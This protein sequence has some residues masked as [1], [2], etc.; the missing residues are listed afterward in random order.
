M[1][2]FASNLWENYIKFRN[3]EADADK[4]RFYK[5]KV[6]ANP[7]GGMLTIQRPLDSQTYSVYCASYMANTT[8]GSTVLVIKYGEGTNL[9]NHFVIDNAERTVMETSISTAQSTADS[10][11]SVAAAAQSSA[12][13]ASRSATAAQSSAD[14][15]ARAAAS[16]QSTADDAADA[17]SD[18]QSS[19][20]AASRAATAAQSTADSAATA[21]SNAQTSANNAATAASNAQTS[22]NNAQTSAN[23]AAT[24]ASN[25]QA[26]ATTANNAANNA[27]TQLSIVED[28]AGTLAW[29]QEHGTYTATTDTTVV[30]G[31]VY[32][33]YD[34]STGDY[35]PIVAPDSEANPR[36]NGWYELDISDSQTE[37]IMAHLAVTSRGLWVL[38]SGMGT[39]TN[40]QYAPNYKVLLSADGMYLYDGSGA[41]VVKYGSSISFGSDRAFAIGDTSGTN[42][43]AF[44][45]NQGIVI[46]GGVSIGSNK[47]LA[48]IL[49]TVEIESSAGTAFKNGT[50]STTL[51]C[52]VY[53][54]GDE[55]DATGSLYSYQWYLN[56]TAISG[57]T[58]KTYSVSASTIDET[59]TYTCEVTV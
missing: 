19:A 18:A 3:K 15:A 4:V 56:G 17:A 29:I 25:A 13:S 54:Y 22:A 9:R 58:G 49:F 35:S 8:V 38:P 11:A 59:A 26:S 24:A 51:T 50:G 10:A 12:E 20:D 33:E 40:A 46:G 57:A 47:T 34:S 16:A 32:F 53:Q 48:E 39:A 43:I 1:A 28:V 7:G 30:T 41:Q 6:V 44:T 27:L 23:N 14:E 31:K 36:T 45:P 37:Y 55:V 21:A 42:Y 5:A 2:E 52:R